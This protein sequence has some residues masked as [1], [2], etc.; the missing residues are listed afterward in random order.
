MLRGTHV[1]SGIG[2]LHEVLNVNVL[3]LEVEENS[4]AEDFTAD[5]RFD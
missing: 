1:A 4:V 3:F 5:A 2:G